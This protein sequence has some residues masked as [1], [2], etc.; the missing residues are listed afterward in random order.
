[1]TLPPLRHHALQSKPYSSPRLKACD[2][3]SLSLQQHLMAQHFLCSLIMA[4]LLL[5]LQT[6]ICPKTQIGTHMM[7]IHFMPQLQA[8]DV[9]CV[10]NAADIAAGR[11]ASARLVLWLIQ[12]AFPFKPHARRQETS[13]QIQPMMFPVQTLRQTP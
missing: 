11:N 12:C 4:V 13:L 7:I 5:A 10:H 9:S 1:M 8:Q 2:Q 6:P 3:L